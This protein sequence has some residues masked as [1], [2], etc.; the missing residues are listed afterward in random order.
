MTGQGLLERRPSRLFHSVPPCRHVDMLGL[1]SLSILASKRCTPSSLSSLRG[2][3]SRPVKG[4]FRSHR[5]FTTV[6]A[7]ASNVTAYAPRKKHLNAFGD[8]HTPGSQQYAPQETDGVAEDSRSKIAS[9]HLRPPPF[10]SESDSIHGNTHVD[11]KIWSMDP[12][13]AQ[14]LRSLTQ[15]LPPVNLR[16]IQG[17]SDRFR[18]QKLTTAEVSM[19][20]EIFKVLD[21]I[22]TQNT[23]LGANSSLDLLRIVQAFPD[24]LCQW[25]ILHLVEPRSRAAQLWALSVLHAL[26]RL[27]H[28]LTSEV[29]GVVKDSDVQIPIH[30]YIELCH[31]F[32]LPP[33]PADLENK[34]GAY[35]KMTRAEKANA[36]QSVLHHAKQT[37]NSVIILSCWN[38]TIQGLLAQGDVVGAERE[39]TALLRMGYTPPIE[40]L[41]AFIKFY[42]K[43]V[44]T[45]PQYVEKVAAFHARIK[46][47]N[48]SPDLLTYSA[49][50]QCYE[51][52]MRYKEMDS[53][54]LEM[55]Q[56][57]LRLQ[58]R[59]KTQQQRHRDD[60]HHHQ[61]DSATTAQNL[62][63]RGPRAT[64]LR[65]SD[66]DSD[67]LDNW[68]DLSTM[69]SA[70]PSSLPSSSSLAMID[71]EVITAPTHGPRAALDKPHQDRRPT[72]LDKHHPSSLAS[73]NPMEN[74]DSVDIPF[75]SDTHS[76]PE[77]QE[78]TLPTFDRASRVSAARASSPVDL[79][80]GNLVYTGGAQW[81]G[82]G[83]KQPTKSTIVAAVEKTLLP[84]RPVTS[85]Q[86][87]AIGAE[88][89]NLKLT[90]ENLAH[91]QRQ[92]HE[93]VLAERR[94]SLVEAWSRA[95]Y[96]ALSLGSLRKAM[97]LVEEMEMLGLHINDRICTEFMFFAGKRGNFQLLES[98]WKRLCSLPGSTLLRKHYLIYM[99]ELLRLD[100]AKE[101]RKVMSHLCTKFGH[102]DDAYALWLRYYSNKGLNTSVEHTLKQMEANSVEFG[103]YSI[104]AL[105]EVFAKRGNLQEMFNWLDRLKLMASTHALDEVLAKCAYQFMN[106]KHTL[107]DPKAWLDALSSPPSS[108]PRLLG[109]LMITLGTQKQLSSLEYVASLCSDLN[110][111]HILVG[112]IRGYSMIPPSPKRDYEVVQMIEKCTSLKYQLNTAQNEDVLKALIRL[113]MPSVML[114]WEEALVNSTTHVVEPSSTV[115]E[116]VAQA[117]LNIGKP[118]RFVEFCSKS[119]DK[120]GALPPM[121]A[122][123][124]VIRAVC[125]TRDLD[126]TLYI[127]SPLASLFSHDPTTVLLILD[128]ELAQI[129]V[130]RPHSLPSP[131]DLANPSTLDIPSYIS[132]RLQRS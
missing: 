63:V 13:T 104:G 39:W 110:N 32:G 20:G 126:R 125:S 4:P 103:L 106:Q 62:K 48:K 65:D 76:T 90:A 80:V 112:F 84:Q 70:S 101:A 74:G 37:G 121:H 24:Q 123:S 89:G 115:F 2:T 7:S 113:E 97:F 117:S 23:S 66:L 5:L 28:P 36:L 122:I 131:K 57:E 14:K 46:Q 111:P 30:A 26:A 16:V 73:S 79:K 25:S 27:Q 61:L 17:R 29:W 86:L 77:Q 31:Y 12:E 10:S 91:A 6:R 68:S 8:E 40:L 119:S 42:S 100:K 99:R 120:Y 116:I 1:S 69:T 82:G 102:S 50:M 19:L 85:R 43:H 56:R 34:L 129:G 124:K 52:S 88:E 44:K 49:I 95:I 47:L 64:Q 21:L 71:W 35:R 130:R 11:Y 75:K 60:H 51:R 87:A 118:E 105:M 78:R 114:D 55:T 92:R 72:A 38:H 108:F 53:V 93:D 67:S 18:P 3:Q 58:Q 94:A 96:A 128:D 81:A 41:Q 54:L 83:R 107:K 127:S 33:E 15:K 109:A 9:T 98:W 22:V 45:H 59:Q 132:R